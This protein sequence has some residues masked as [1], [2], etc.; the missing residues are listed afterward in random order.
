MSKMIRRMLPLLAVLITAL[1]VTAGA[2]EVKA[3]IFDYAKVSAPAASGSRLALTNVDHA[4]RVRIPGLSQADASTVSVSSSNRKVATVIFYK[5]LVK[6]GWIRV[7]VRK[8]GKTNIKLSYKTTA[9]VSKNY[10]LTLFTY[11]YE[12][13]LKLAKIGIRDNTSLLDETNFTHSAKIAIGKA[14]V[15]MTPNKGWKVL[16]VYVQGYKKNGKYVTTQIKNYATYNFGV[17]ASRPDIYVKTF[18]AKRNLTLIVK[19][20]AA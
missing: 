20:G 4:W 2:A 19:L 10:E 13:P 17:F 14:R 9:G 12:N 6:E 7:N 15:N 5:N 11:G 18:Y 16:G 3:E 8:A 1:A